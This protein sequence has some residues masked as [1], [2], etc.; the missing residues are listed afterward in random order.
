M[1]VALLVNRENY[2]KYSNWADTG[3]ELVHFGNGEPDP[4]RIIETNAEALVVDA[5]MK[6]GPDIISN[7]PDLKLIHSQGVAYNGIDTGAA[8]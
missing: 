1:K 5:I 7:M 2:E 6:I 3:W 8:Q 4:A